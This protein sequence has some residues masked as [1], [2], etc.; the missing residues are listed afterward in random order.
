MLFLDKLKKIIS[1][2]KIP[3][4]ISF[5]GLDQ[6]GKT[7]I[8][9]RVTRGYF[10]Q[11]TIRTLGMNVDQFT[12]GDVQ[13]ITWDV[14]GQIAFR[15]KL[16]KDYIVGSMGIVFVI[17]AA[18]RDRFEEVKEELWKHV[19]KNPDTERIPILILANKQDL[20]NAADEGEIVVSLDLN[21]VKDRSYR[22]FLTS[23][24][25]GLNVE[26]SLQWLSEEIKKIV[27]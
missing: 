1:K 9:K 12:I 21:R 7:T 24:K 4:K 10:D 6:A 26:E 2:K 14:G 20:P 15:N 18:D 22:I 3:V 27:K 16:W 5:I 13:F 8:I 19:I 17:D 11:A 25:T 23:A